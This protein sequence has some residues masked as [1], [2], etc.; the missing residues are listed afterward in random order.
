MEKLPEDFKKRWLEALRSGKYRKGRKRLYT[1]KGYND[2][3]EMDDDEYCCLGVAAVICGV[4]K[5]G[6]FDDDVP[7]LFIHEFFGSA[8]IVPPV[9]CGG[10]K[11]NYIVDRLVD[12]NDN[13]AGWEPVIDFIEKT[14]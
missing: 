9:L 6:L 4:R 11:E 2:E 12:L 1:P 8:G 10:T 7:Q 14:L 3:K 13:N 5:E